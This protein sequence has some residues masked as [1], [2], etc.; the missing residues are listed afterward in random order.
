MLC[1]RCLSCF[2]LSLQAPRIKG[3]LPLGI[4]SR[5]CLQISCPVFGVGKLREKV[6]NYRNLMVSLSWPHYLSLLGWHFQIIKDYVGQL[7][8][9]HRAVGT[10]IFC[11]LSGCLEDITTGQLHLHKTS[12]VIWSSL[13]SRKEKTRRK[14][15]QRQLQELSWEAPVRA[16]QFLGLEKQYGLTGEGCAVR[17]GLPARSD[18]EVW[19]WQRCLHHCM[20]RTRRAT[21]P[22]QKCGAA[23]TGKLT[24]PASY[25]SVAD[26]FST[27]PSANE[28]VVMENIAIFEKIR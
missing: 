24:T 1:G 17:L 5:K 10:W 25:H 2:V 7:S 9:P 23:L 4:C 14:T 13:T 16:E 12:A 27:Y 28:A 22:F 21:L 20:H 15:R 11:G 8:P 18:C 6:S 3:L 19:R 26:W